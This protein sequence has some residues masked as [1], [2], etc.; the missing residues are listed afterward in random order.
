MKRKRG[1]KKGLLLAPFVLYLSVFSPSLLFFSVI[2]CQWKL[3]KEN[4]SRIPSIHFGEAIYSESTENGITG[5]KF[6]A[7]TPELCQVSFQKRPISFLTVPPQSRHTSWF[8]ASD[9]ANG[10]YFWMPKSPGVSCPKAFYALNQTE[11]YPTD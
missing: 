9:P 1:T 5:S 6:G 8:Q 4:T 10:H 11:T 2:F 3:A 7:A